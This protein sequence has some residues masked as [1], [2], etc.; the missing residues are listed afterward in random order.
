MIEI[1]PAR[2]GDAERLAKLVGLL[3]HEIDAATLWAHT[4]ELQAAGI[5]QLVAEEDGVVLGFVGL[6]R[7]IVAYRDRPVA[8]ITILVTAEEARGRG[9]GRVLVKAAI[10][11]AREW[12]CGLLEVTSNER[13]G[14]AHRFYRHMGFDQTSKRFALK[15]G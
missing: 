7:M 4:V 10:D 14:E 15:V 6:N 1:R 12:G 11:K 3:D 9:I 2:Q 5:P 8:R 13:L